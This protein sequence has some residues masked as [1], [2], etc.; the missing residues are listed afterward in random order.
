MHFVPGATRL[1][2]AGCGSDDQAAATDA[3]ARTA[4]HEELD[5]EAHWRQQ[6]ASEP[7]IDAHLVAC[8]HCGAQT[9]FDDHVVAAVC[10]FCATPLASSTAQ[11]AR[12]IRPRGVVPFKVDAPR[13]QKLFRDWLSRRWFTPNAL[14]ATV[15]SLEGMRGVY[16]PCWTFDA[17]T[18]SEYEGERGTDRRV[19]ETE[20][21]ASGRRVTTTRTETDW[22]DV[23]GVVEWRFDDT[24]VLASRSVPA[25]LAEVLRDWDVSD[26]QPFSLGYVAGF[27]V[28]AYHLGLEEGFGQAKI[29]FDERI[30]EAVRC[31]IGGD[32]QR[33]DKVLTQYR[34]VTFKHILLPLWICSYPFKGK[35][36]RVV[37][38]GQTGTVKGDRP[39][40]AWK[41]GF[42]VAAALAVVAAGY[43]FVHQA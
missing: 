34:E 35:T 15:R 21:D 38:N 4:M 14:K 42:S 11:A 25:P 5:Y 12:R 24:L 7:T 28:E 10:A 30:K 29:I 8:P 23:S 16:L 39:W 17:Q 1:A 43:W 36:W 13:A 37:V 41:I 19:T 33:I 18:T 31:D 9:Q 27:T 22:V 6:L 20:T 40:S 32:R 3:A 26:M 2:C